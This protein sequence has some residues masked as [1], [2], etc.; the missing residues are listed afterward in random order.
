MK[1]SFF[2]TSLVWGF[3]LWLFGYILGILLFFMVTP[4][5][6]GWIIAPFGIVATLWVLVKKVHLKSFKEYILLAVVWFF[7]AII[8][9]YFLLVKLFK[10]ADG[11]YK[12]DV[13]IYYLMTLVLP[14]I[15]AWK[16]F[17]RTVTV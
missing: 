14:I 3:L 9:D 13:Y 12:L 6:I 5:L 4:S 7:T 10:P 2:R 11:Y 16:K 1:Y 17:H 8:C 15:V